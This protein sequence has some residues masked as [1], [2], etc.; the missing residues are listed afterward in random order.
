MVFTA[1]GKCHATGTG[2]GRW[3]RVPEGLPRG[4]RFTN[5]L[6]P[7]GR[8]GHEAAMAGAKPPA[9]AF[10]SVRRVDELWALGIR[11]WAFAS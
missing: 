4:S 9:L 3:K 8:N 7:Q 11:H 1:Y 2:T 10:V 6:P 5:V